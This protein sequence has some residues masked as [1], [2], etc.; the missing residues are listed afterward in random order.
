MQVLKDVVQAFLEDTPNDMNQLRDA[1]TKGDY[2]RV[3]AQAHK[4]KGAA[5]VIG[6]Q[7]TSQA[8]L[9]LEATAKTENVKDVE[10]NVDELS[11]QLETLSQT[12]NQYLKESY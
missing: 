2:P 1:L 9:Y 10:R 11:H 12:L 3:S 6:A 5:A 7:A 8:A 4:I